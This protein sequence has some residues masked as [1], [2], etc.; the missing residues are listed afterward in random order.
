MS[1]IGEH[2]TLVLIGL[3]HTYSPT[4]LLDAY[5]SYTHLT[6][7]RTPQN[8][9]VNFAGIIPGL[10]PQQIEGAPQ[11]SITN[12][13]SIAEQGSKDLE[14]QIQGY[15]TLTK[16]LSRHTIKT[17]V[18]SL[19]QP[20]ETRNH[21]QRGSYAFTNKYTPAM[22]TLTSCWVCPPHAGVISR[23]TCL[24]QHHRRANFRAG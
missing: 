13:T 21:P 3:T 23:R 6:T 4:L 22:P 8:V 11:I 12:I 9:N 17:G 15:S 19:L 16:V 10:P 14:Q 5:A 7:Y 1:G 20:L 2:N 24:P 18:S